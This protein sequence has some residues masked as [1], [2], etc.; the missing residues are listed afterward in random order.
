MY[1]QNVNRWRPG[2]LQK[3]GNA[4]TDIAKEELKSGVY[5]KN[6]LQQTV[7]VW[8]P[9]DLGDKRNNAEADEN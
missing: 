1:N 8:G 7:I 9:E 6:N 5:C 2:I 3:A 4:A